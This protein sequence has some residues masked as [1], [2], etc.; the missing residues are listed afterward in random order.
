M[1]LS[2]ELWKRSSLVVARLVHGT[3][4]PELAAS[5][6]SLIQAHVADLAAR[7]SFQARHPHSG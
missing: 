2:N 7:P 5:M 3:Q 1:K 6:D 4:I